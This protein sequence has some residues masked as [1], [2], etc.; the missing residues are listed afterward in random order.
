MLLEDRVWR[1]D[2]MAI[3]FVSLARLDR[4]ELDWLRREYVE[5]EKSVEHFI[6]KME[7]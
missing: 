2:V 7:E 3:G 1:A 4:V 6:E 5:L